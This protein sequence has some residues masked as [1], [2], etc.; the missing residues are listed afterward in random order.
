VAS[1]LLYK[2]HCAYYIHM[3]RILLYYLKFAEQSTTLFILV[4]QRVTDVSV[5]TTCLLVI[6]TSAQKFQLAAIPNVVFEWYLRDAGYKP[7][8]GGRPSSHGFR[9]FSS[10]SK[11]LSNRTLNKVTSASFHVLFSSYFSDHRLIR[12]CVS[13]Q[14]KSSLCQE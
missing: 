11:P 9:V 6:P 7:R 14:L 1:L 3:T 8:P 5:G 12:R 10:L 4:T 2:L 13:E